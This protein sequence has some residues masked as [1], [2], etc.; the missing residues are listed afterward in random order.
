MTSH[1]RHQSSLEGVIDFSAQSL[2]PDERNRAIQIFKQIIDHYEPAQSEQPYKRITLIRVTQEYTLS[3][4]N[5]LE[6]FFLYIGKEIRLRELNSSYILSDLVQFDSWDTERKN[7]LEPH[8][9][10]FADYLIDNFFLPCKTDLN[11]RYILITDI[12]LVKASSR[13]TPQPTPAA[14]SEAS[15]KQQLT[16]TTQRISTL[17]RDC[18][19]RDRHRC[20]ISRKFD[21]Q[22]AE[23]RTKKDGDNFKDDDGYWLRDEIDFEVLEVAHILPHSLMSFSPGGEQTELVC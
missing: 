2:E 5:F 3:Q 8:L 7:G 17:R 19:I 20:V 12:N 10:A 15:T 16:G 11:F 1:H 14:L 4:N 23:N 18:L 22:E 13:K 6:H 9:I 21:L